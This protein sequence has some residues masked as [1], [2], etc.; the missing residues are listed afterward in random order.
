MK[1]HFTRAGNSHA[2]VA[3]TGNKLKI[4]MIFLAMLLFCSN[5]GFATAWTTVGA[6]NIST[7]SN[8]TDGS[9]APTSFATPGDTWTIAHPMS[10]SSGSPW[11]VGTAA[12]AAVTV[13]VA[14]GGTVSG[15]SGAFQLLM[16][17]Y[18]NV[19]IA[20][21]IISNGGG[22]LLLMNVY[23]NMSMT[24]GALVTNGGGC[25]L[26]LNVNGNLTMSGGAIVANGGGAIDT[27]RVKGNFSASGSSFIMS[28]GGAATGVVFLS[29]PS[30]SGVMLADNTS[31]GSWGANPVY[32]DAGCTAQ[33][34]G[35]FSTSVG[36]ITGLTVNGTL[37]CPATF[38]V[39]GIDKFT[40]N[41]GGTLKVANPTGI[42]GAI[43]T[44]GTKTF[45]NSANYEF[46]G[47][48]A[49]VTGSFLPV[50]LV[51]PDT[52]TVNNS[53][54][55]TLSQTTA[56]T[57]TL[58]FASGILN[59]TAAYTMSVPGTASSVVGAGAASYVNGTLIKSVSGLTT[60]NFEVGDLDYAP[61]KLTLSASGT[62]GSIGLQT[63]NGLHP[64]VAT[65]GLLS[66]NMANH[67]WT[68][69]NLSVSGPGTVTVQGTYNLSDII[70]GTNTAFQ[71]QEYTG[72]AWLGAPLVTANT[73]S[74]YTS[75]TVSGVPLA[76]LA[77]DYIFGNIFC[78]TLPITGTTTVCGGATVTLSDATAGGTWS[79]ST[80]TIA[81]VGAAGVVTGVSGGTTTISYTSSGCTVTT[82]VTVNPAPNAGTISSA[83]TIVCVGSTISAS[84]GATGG[85]WGSTN[86][87]FASVT[88]SGVVNGIAP[89]ID[90]ITYSVTN[91]CGTAVAKF[92]I[93]VLS[94]VAC[95]HLGTNSVGSEQQTELKIY[96]NPSEGMFTLTLLSNEDAS[97][98][99]V[100][101]NV[102][103]ETVTRFST[104]TNKPTDLKLDLAPGVYLV[105]ASTN[106]G[107]YN[108]RIMIR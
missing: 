102:L 52:I 74:P 61:M 34:D 9:V 75:L 91:G 44:S 50:A 41:S 42:N 43:I 30:A 35:N 99:V 88:A 46:N 77:G 8:W 31:T 68:I 64:S 22:C 101:S 45:S 107:R 80:P 56:T 16:N 17:I 71:T 40:L 96:P 89:G 65:S 18:G 60:L 63:T 14:S 32:V 48:A 5:Y 15:S 98:D 28:N 103:G 92:R 84:D 86:T 1:G 104:T 33:L 73:V 62:G 97:A 36:S 7:L 90:T 29:L 3:R 69:T 54:G 12:M 23:G 20:D 108:A 13:T 21:S 49:Q 94:V 105:S 58:S 83:D 66:S 100:V 6:G 24:A 27:V 79:S 82:V 72:S 2:A 106:D 19:V 78:G 25:I 47:S 51:A 95:A 53:A 10:I 70:G 4:Q 38:F 57:G 39:N 67:Y 37:I 76:S 93:K 85:T 55:V 87:A 11:N 59:T 81:T 26:K